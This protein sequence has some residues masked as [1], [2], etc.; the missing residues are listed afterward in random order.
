HPEYQVKA[1]FIYNFTG[2]VEWPDSVFASPKAP[3]VI[4]VYG[5]NPF[6]NYLNEIVRNETVD[7]HPIEVRPVTNSNEFANCHILFLNPGQK[8]N[9]RELLDVAERYP[10]L[11]VSDHPDFDRAGGIIRLYTDQNR[12]RLRINISAAQEAN[13]RISS[14]LLKVAELTDQ[15]R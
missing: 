15:K 1:A 9:M 10:V 4:G 7:G 8:E 5:K 11:T 13:L 12:V 3:L 6:S 14:K 2:F